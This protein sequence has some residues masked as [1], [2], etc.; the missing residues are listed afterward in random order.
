MVNIF[1]SRVSQ[2]LGFSVSTRSSLHLTCVNVI[3]N[4]RDSSSV[5]RRSVAHTASF[6]P[7]AN[8]VDRAQNVISRRVLCVV[9]RARKAAEVAQAEI[10]H[11]KLKSRKVIAL[12]SSGTDRKVS[13]TS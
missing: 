12:T 9:A 3:S 5:R 6:P 2:S 8:V 13:A 10:V 1:I 11:P 4:V 7:G